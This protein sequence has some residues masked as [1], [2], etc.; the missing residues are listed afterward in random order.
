MHTQQYPSGGC[1]EKQTVRALAEE[2][3]QAVQ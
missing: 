2:C 1:K 3:A